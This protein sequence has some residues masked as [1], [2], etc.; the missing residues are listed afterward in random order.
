MFYWILKIL[1]YIP[2]HLLYPTKIVGKKNFPKKGKCIVVCNHQSYM[3]A[4]II[5]VGINRKVRFLSKIEFTKNLFM[6]MLLS[7]IEVIF[8]DRKQTSISSIKIC[9]NELQRNKCIGIFPEGTRIKNRTENEPIENVKD[10][11]SLLALKS[12]AQI[13][14]MRLVNKPR[15]FRRN[16]LIIGEPF[17]LDKS[18]ERITHEDI[19]LGS[20]K[21]F[22]KISELK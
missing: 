5:C 18:N 3:D 21:I 4:V 6:R 22:D 11:T 13:V 16:T 10:G 1:A 20:E 14:P 12:D 17:M 8:V 15:L 2:Q 9:L 7:M 19:K